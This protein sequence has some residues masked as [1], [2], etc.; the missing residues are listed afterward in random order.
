MRTFSTNVSAV[1]LTAILSTSLVLSGCGDKN[2]GKSTSSDVKIEKVEARKVDNAQA[3]KALTALS[4]SE[5][6]SGS[7]SW[8]AKTGDSGNYVF[9]DVVIQG[10]DSDDNPMNVETLELKG[11][12]MVGDLVAFDVITLNNMSTKDDD[13]VVAIKKIELIK[14]SPSISNEIAK[15]FGG[16]DDAFDDMDGE[17]GIGGF[18]MV[19]LDV[20]SDDGKIS[21]DKFMFGEAKDKTGV[22]TLKNLNMDIQ[23]DEDVKI[24][25]GSVDVTG[26]NLEKYKGLIQASMEAGENGEEIGQ[27]AMK[28]LMNSMNPY[29]PDY[30]N[31]S[32]KDFDMDI[33]GLTVDVDSI[34]GK[35]TTKNGIT[36]ITQTT[37]PMII[38]PPAE[39]G[40]KEMQQFS[41]ALKDM[42]YDRLVFQS[43][44]K[45]ILDE[46]TDSV[47]VVDSYLEMQDG[48]KLNF[49]YNLSGIKELMDKA[50]A[51]G[52]NNKASDNPLA[53]M[54]LLSSMKISKARIALEDKSI[55]ERGFKFAAK[56]Q[57]ADPS[58][59]RNSA[60]AGLAFL[61]MMAKDPA[62]QALAM[63]ASQAL[64]S[65]LDNSG[66]LIIEMNPET[67]V[68]MGAITSGAQQGDIDV[69]TLGLSIRNE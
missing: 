30:K 41:A 17:V 16:D 24:T 8:A 66:T 58:M 23:D 22:F 37:S 64:G 38:T 14:P 59:L 57:G 28:K 44:S 11:A 6:G 9:T 60:K 53:A 50:T 20:T 19:G 47:E 7:L 45:S 63:E 3:E 39:G 52:A 26:L 56:Q 2:K 62:Q 32:L 40:K 42:G 49:D 21:M 4:L 29:S 68:D 54:E 1:A 13:A 18:D 69:S 61:P 5:S 34:D 48:F 67:P 51:F 27:D 36:T 12:H 33:S 35:T 31:F 10:G 46:A 55:I 43:S 25:L 65:F 15:A